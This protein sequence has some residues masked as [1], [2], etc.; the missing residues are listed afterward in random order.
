MTKPKLDIRQLI[1]EGKIST[2]KAGQLVALEVY[3]NSGMLKES[4]MRALKETVKD[5][6]RYNAYMDGVNHIGRIDNAIAGIMTDA[7]LSTVRIGWT[8]SEIRFTVRALYQVPRV[9][10]VT[11]EGYKRLGDDKRERRLKRTY[12]LMTLYHIIAES[13]IE[14]PVNKTQKDAVAALKAE[15]EE[16]KNENNFYGID[17]I[18]KGY[19]IW[20]GW[21]AYYDAQGFTLADLADDL[22][23]YH[24]L[25]LSIITQAHKDRKLSIDPATVP[26]EKWH[27]T[28]LKG[29]ELKT[30]G[31]VTKLL[32]DSINLPESR[33]NVLDEYDDEGETKDNPAGRT[34]RADYELYSQKYAIITR[35]YLY[36]NELTDGELDPSKDYYS[37]DLDQWTS[38]RFGYGALR[39]LSDERGMENDMALSLIKQKRHELIEALRLLLVLTKWRERSGELLGISKADRFVAQTKRVSPTVIYDEYNNHRDIYYG[40]LSGEQVIDPQYLEYL[41]LL[42]QALAPLHNPDTYNALSKEEKAMLFNPTQEGDV[43]A[44]DKNPPNTLDGIM[45][46]RSLKDPYALTEAMLTEHKTVADCLALINGMSLE[47]IASVYEQITDDLIA[48]ETPIIERTKDAV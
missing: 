9:R 29:S 19:E 39:H 28:P 34:E 42:R 26:L 36:K 4:D 37:R 31:G 40:A 2:D 24:A 5:A 41:E 3:E 33:D 6:R 32:D 16:H 44:Y 13:I 7:R 8:L 11:P 23:D 35:P 10:V 48:L 14:N 38:P 1:R 17:L 30:L 27:K 22:P 47:G 21:T 46:Y 12:T 15:A 43:L 25:V 20:A 18:D 45:K